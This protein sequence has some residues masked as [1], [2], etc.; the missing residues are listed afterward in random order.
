MGFPFYF[1]GD[2]P[3]VLDFYPLTWAHGAGGLINASDT[4]GKKDAG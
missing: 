4:P 3:L 1:K 2:F